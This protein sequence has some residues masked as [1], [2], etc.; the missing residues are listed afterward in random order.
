MKIGCVVVTYNKKDLLQECLNAINNQTFKVDSIFIIDNC[1]TDGTSQ[2]INVMTE[3]YKN[4]KYFRL[5]KNIGGAGGFNYGLKEAYKADIDY[6]WIMDDDTIPKNTALENLVKIVNSSGINW[7]F[8][9]S[10]VKWI[11]NTPCLMNVP[12]P[13]GKWNESLELGIVNVEIATFV[14]LLIPKGILQEVGLPIKEFFI[15]GDDTEFTS[16]INKVLPGYLVSDS[17]VIHKMGVNSGVDIINDTNDRLN[18]YYFR[19]RNKVYMAKK[20][21]L[22]EFVKFSFH[23][24]YIIGQ[25]IWKKNKNKT[26]KITNVSKGYIS[27]LFFNPEIEFPY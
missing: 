11:D 19:Y 2:M 15:W 22:K 9:C 27:G 8:L 16:R 7:G 4:I 14:S 26:K 20:S 5:D 12:K 17:E 18:R 3:E 21:G 13:S 25:I 23:T 24:L 1:S 10:N 6:I